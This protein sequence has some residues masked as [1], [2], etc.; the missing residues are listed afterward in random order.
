MVSS[1]H[2]SPEQSPLR[3]ALVVNADPEVET[4]LKDVLPA[5]DWSVLNAANNAEVLK[6]VETKPFD[7]IITSDNTSA[8]EDVELL[9]KIRKVRPHVRLI[10]ITDKSTPADV[11]ASMREHAFSYFS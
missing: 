2:P 6:L 4:L 8:K 5:G 7:L 9:R 11:V 10:I 1:P 3:T